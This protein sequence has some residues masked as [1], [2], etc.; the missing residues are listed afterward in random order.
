MSEYIPR[1][2][3]YTCADGETVPIQVRQSGRARK[4][5]LCLREGRFVMTVPSS[6]P[7]ETLKT[8][9]PQ[10]HPWIEERHRETLI[11]DVPKEI[12]KSIAIPVERTEY[13]VNLVPDTNA[14]YSH[15]HSARQLTTGRTPDGTKTVYCLEF[16]DKLELIGNVDHKKLTAFS[17]QSWAKRKADFVLVKHLRSIAAELNISVAKVTIR[18][19][20]S[21][22]GSCSEQPDK[23]CNISLNWRAL[24]LPVDQLTH[25]CHHELCHVRHMNHSRAFHKEMLSI[26]KNAESL[27]VKLGEAWKKLPWWSRHIDNL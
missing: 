21:R 12:P 22:W 14:L 9:F 3:S 11:N 8:T 20:R 2:I 24:L 25:L 17:L 23:L 27:E 4:I 26:D 16:P 7:P 6:L 15:I 10:M 18:D 5:T 1:E 19:Q 13:A